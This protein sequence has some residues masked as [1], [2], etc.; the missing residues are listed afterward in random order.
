[1]EDEKLLELSVSLLSGGHSPL[2]QAEPTRPQGSVRLR[3]GRLHVLLL[4]K[5][6]AEMQVRASS[7]DVERMPIVVFC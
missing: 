1:M 3:V 6:V 2:D 5:I 7:A 4:H